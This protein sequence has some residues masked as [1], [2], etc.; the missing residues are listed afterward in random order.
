MIAHMSISAPVCQEIP[1]LVSKFAPLLEG[2]HYQQMRFLR[3]YI[4]LVFSS[5]ANSTK[6]TK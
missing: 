3:N 4:C 2:F 1:V 6:T 5:V